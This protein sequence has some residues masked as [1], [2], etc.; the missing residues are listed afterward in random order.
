MRGLPRPRTYL[1]GCLFPFPDLVGGMVMSHRPFQFRP[2][3]EAFENRLCPSGSTVV[4]PISAFLAQQGHDSVFAPPVRDQQAWSNSMYDPGATPSD[5]TLLLLTDFTGQAAQYL[6]QNGINLHTMVTGFVTETT[7]GTTGL[8]EVS[9]N[10][11]A[12][13]ALT[14]VVNI[15]GIDANQ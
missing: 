1:A 6:L 13:K 12:T 11:E 15:A 8:M 3:L 10:L 2:Q 7:I 4:L 9:V 5:P 14:W